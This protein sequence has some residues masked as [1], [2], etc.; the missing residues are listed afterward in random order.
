APVEG[1]GIVLT[2]VA[3]PTEFDEAYASATTPLPEEV[4]QEFETKFGVRF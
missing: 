1:N 2:G 4:W 3:N